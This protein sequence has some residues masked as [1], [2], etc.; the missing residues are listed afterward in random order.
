MVILRV[1][2]NTHE[3][4]DDND[5][6][7]GMV[8]Q[9]ATLLVEAVR[10]KNFRHGAQDRASVIKSASLTMPDF[11]RFQIKFGKQNLRLPSPFVA[12]S[13]FFFFVF[14]FLLRQYTA[15]AGKLKS[16]LDIHPMVTPW[17]QSSCS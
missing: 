11:L 15:L 8:T 5:N 13:G 16:R 4:D 6:T 14:F 3:N 1:G 10:P 2:G 9:L 17:S 12:K 7:D